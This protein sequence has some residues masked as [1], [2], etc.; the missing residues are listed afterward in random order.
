MYSLV[1]L[2]S[3]VYPLP[4]KAAMHSLLVTYSVFIRT[5]NFELCG[6]LFNFK[7]YLNLKKKLENFLI[8]I[9]K[10]FSVSKRIVKILLCFVKAFTTLNRVRT[11]VKGPILGLLLL[12]SVIPLLSDNSEPIN[13]VG[14]AHMQKR[15]IYYLMSPPFWQYPC[16]IEINV[17]N[18][19]HFP[20]VYLLG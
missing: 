13:G 15:H 5:P 9:F 19:R 17:T 4:A 1:S 18:N 20:F 16:K 3:G 2:L 14:R 11:R 6:W 10:L 7:F 12:L 8:K